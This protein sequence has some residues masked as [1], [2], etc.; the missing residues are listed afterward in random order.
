MV[1]DVLMQLIG[2]KD[3]FCSILQRPQLKKSFSSPESASLDL[4][5]KNKKGSALTKGTQINRVY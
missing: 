5:V 4:K 1:S 2:D 3:T